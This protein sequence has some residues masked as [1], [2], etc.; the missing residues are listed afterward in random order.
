MSDDQSP[1]ADTPPPARTRGPSPDKTAQTRQQILAAARAELLDY[2]FSGATM[3]RVAE[4]AGLAKGT[5]Y[6]YF[7]SK[8]ALFLALMRD[9]VT[10]PL[11]ESRGRGQREDETMAAYCRR[12]ILP[13]M[14]VIEEGGRAAIALVAVTESR[15]F[16]EMTETYSRDIFRPFLEHLQAQARRAVARGELTQQDAEQVPHLLMAP[17]WLGI[18][19]NGILN[20]GQPMCIGQAFARQLDLIF[21]PDP[22]A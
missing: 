15:S 6:R 9:L 12:V 20:P 13:L 8:E 2:G 4:R 14:E 11:R 18:I 17:L 10:D 3:L 7:P 16:P 1:E 21:G 19:H 22:A 5:T